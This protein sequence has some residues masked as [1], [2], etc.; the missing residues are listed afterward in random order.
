MDQISQDEN[1]LLDFC[2]QIVH[3]NFQTTSCFGGTLF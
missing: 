1:L 2:V 3:K